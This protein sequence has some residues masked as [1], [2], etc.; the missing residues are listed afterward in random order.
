MYFAYNY[1]SDFRLWVF[2]CGRAFDIEGLTV[3][4]CSF[5]THMCLEVRVF[6]WSVAGSIEASI[7]N[8]EYGMHRLAALF[9][10]ESQS[11]PGSSDERED[12]YFK[13]TSGCIFGGKLLPGKFSR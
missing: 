3:S 6:I 11:V 2:F 12:M 10:Q 9:P 13:V 7:Q 5:I 8:I 4:K 1:N